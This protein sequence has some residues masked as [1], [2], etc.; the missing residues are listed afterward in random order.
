LSQDFDLPCFIDKFGNMCF[1]KHKDDVEDSVRYPLSAKHYG[2]TAREDLRNYEK[3]VQWP[4]RDLLT[5]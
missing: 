2:E 1:K 4:I 5:L 3:Y